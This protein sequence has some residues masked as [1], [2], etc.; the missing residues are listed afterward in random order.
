MPA[1][2]IIK[3]FGNITAG[4]NQD[5]LMAVDIPQDGTIENILMIASPSGMDALDDQLRFELSFGSTST[6]TQN[7]ARISIAEIDVRQN[8]LTTGGGVGIINSYLGRLDIPVAGG[9][10]VHGHVTVS[11]GVGGI[12]GAYLYF[13]ARGRGP[14]RRSIRRR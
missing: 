12:V 7:D 9:E 6:F 13:D 4:V 11:T 8:F 14:G 10:R 5:S 3:M 1:D 2:L